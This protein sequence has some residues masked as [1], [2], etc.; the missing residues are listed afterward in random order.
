MGYFW[1]IFGIFLGLR[2][3]KDTKGTSNLKLIKKNNTKGTSNLKTDLKFGENIIIIDKVYHKEEFDD[4]L[5]CIDIKPPF[6]VKPNWIS[7][8]YGHFTE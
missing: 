2:S 4:F 8:D 3:I 1:D 7:G 6:I 5:K